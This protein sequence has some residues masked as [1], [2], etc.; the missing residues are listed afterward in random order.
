MQ[1]Y[2]F[3]TLNWTW[4]NSTPFLVVFK[5][6]FK[7]RLVRVNQRFA[8]RTRPSFTKLQSPNARLSGEHLKPRVASNARYGA[9]VDHSKL[10]HVI[11]L[12]V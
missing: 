5:G 4:Y 11:C 9:R 7:A 10:M 2:T 6:I 8:P 12:T 1:V 3:T